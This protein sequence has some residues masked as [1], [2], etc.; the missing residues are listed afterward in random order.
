MTQ[1]RVASFSASMV[2]DTYQAA[3]E[4][5]I[6]KFLGKISASRELAAAGALDDAEPDAPPDFF[7]EEMKHLTNDQ[8]R[9][10]RRAMGGFSAVMT[11][12]LEAHKN[13][14]PLDKSKASFE[15]A[16]GDQH[17][18]ELLS[19]YLLYMSLKLKAPNR[20][21]LLRRSL[22][23]VAISDFEV[24]VGALASAVLEDQPG[25]I[26]GA[27]SSFTLRQIKEFGSI[28]AVSE[29]V[30]E[31][32]V[33]DLLR[34]DIDD[35]KSWF[36]KLSVKLEDTTDDWPGFVEMFARRNVLVHNDGKANR[37]YARKLSA[38][39]PQVAAIKVGTELPVSGEYLDDAWNRLSAAACL[40]GIGLLL[41]TR[42]KVDSRQ[43]VQWLIYR[44]EI[45]ADSGSHK[46]VLVIASTVL[47][48]S[49]GRLDRENEISLR[50]LRWTALRELGH[51]E[52][53]TREVEGWDFSGL[54]LLHLHVRD[55][56]LGDVEKACSS[57]ASLLELGRLTRF[58][59]RTKALYRPLHGDP[60][61]SDLLRVRA[62]L[63]GT[64]ERST[65]IEAG[66]MTLAEPADEQ[67]DTPRT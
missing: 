5:A 35:W 56:L 3:I 13:N 61:F 34:G 67:L 50:R 66:A 63:P 51:L 36:G 62:A 2:V 20:A 54:D 33:E 59:L 64:A 17:T 10:V 24:F 39:L 53:M 49:R 45:L 22:L 25:R 12:A 23:I 43:H 65:D 28:E 26:E 8:R 30:I 9:E 38:V 57:I 55:V 14:E 32:K 47:R 48:T 19:R 42:P 46:A 27:D 40:V 44:T 21:Q 60:R 6:D 58:A 7:Q 15:F 4:T 29:Y 16:A 52:E 18:A 11:H 41:Q 31:R 1:S 37:H